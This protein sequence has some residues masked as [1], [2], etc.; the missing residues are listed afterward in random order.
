MNVNQREA[1]GVLI[2]ELAG[3]LH[4]GVGDVQF[5]EALERALE[6]GHRKVVVD[7]REVRSI[8][9]SGL[10]ELVR[11]KVTAARREAEIK[12][13]NLDMRVYELISLAAL[14]PAFDLYDSVG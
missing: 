11:A 3:K 8:D 4:H 12:L 1:G 2:L 6:A 13:A 14:V 7:L 10:G 5:R 9:S